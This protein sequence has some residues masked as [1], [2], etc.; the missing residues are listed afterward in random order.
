M[1]AK[2]QDISRPKS[3]D[4]DQYV[5]KTISD[6]F[7]KTDSKEGQLILKANPGQ[8]PALERS[9]SAIFGRPFLLV[10]ID[11]APSESVGPSTGCRFLDQAPGSQVLCEE[12]L[13][14][15]S[16]N[17]SCQDPVL[18]VATSDFRCGALWAVHGG[19]V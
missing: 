9:I 17:D 14:A 7:F 6:L 5:T 4:F 19:T 11:M 16:T 10:E 18:R 12:D 3:L 13:L 8:T 1:C 2:H 15:T